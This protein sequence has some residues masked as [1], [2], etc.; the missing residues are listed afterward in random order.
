MAKSAAPKAAMKA[1]PTYTS[2]AAANTPAAKAA[3]K[4]KAAAAGKGAKTVPQTTVGKGADAGERE[5]L[6][7]EPLLGTI[8]QWR[9]KFGWVKP[10]DEI[11]HPM[12]KKHQGDLFAGQADIEE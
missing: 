7:E 11:E 4:A 2:T 8:V 10:D 9:G 5:I 3:A 6:H 12:A 1:K